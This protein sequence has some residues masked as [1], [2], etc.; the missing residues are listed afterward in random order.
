[1]DKDGSDV[2]KLTD[3]GLTKREDSIG[4]SVLGSPVYM[5]PEVLVPRGIYDRKADIYALGIMLWEMWYGIDAA[6]HIQQRLYTTLEKAVTEEGLRPSMSM[7]HR[8]DEHWEGLIKSC[9][10]TDP[11]RR[12]EA[13][14]VRAFFEKF[15]RH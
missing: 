9:W 7:N 8:P 5:A 13:S 10:D 14:D 15:L 6:E 3:V 4:G 12:P 2:V 11:E 1:M